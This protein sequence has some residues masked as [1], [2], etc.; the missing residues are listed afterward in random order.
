MPG[1]F[2]V[3][4]MWRAAWRLIRGAF[5]SLLDAA[6]APSGVAPLDP[7]RPDD[8]PDPNRADLG[9]VVAFGGDLSVARLVAAYRRGIFP[10]Y[11]KNPILWWSPDPRAVFEL[12]CFHVPRRLGRTIR[13]GRFRVSFDTA[14][15]AVIRACADR[16]E[17]TWINADMIRAF[18]RM[19]AAG[20]AH[21]VEVWQAD[22]LVGGLY[23]V[24]AGALFAGES[25]FSRVSDGSKVALV[26]LIERLRQR[27]YV[28]FDVQILNDHTASLGAVE[29][30]RRE[31]LRRLADAIGREAS[32]G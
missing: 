27:G 23:G 32:F 15:A 24:A 1:G 18:E 29:I 16:A 21:S 19:H 28:L 22:E 7:R 10:Y 25:M 17:G 13:S 6:A 12:D 3:A 20:H 31:Y 30:P 5:A 2:L 9:D 8:F 4:V 14:F 11:E 26:A